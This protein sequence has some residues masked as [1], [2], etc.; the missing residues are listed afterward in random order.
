LPPPPPTTYSEAELASLREENLLLIQQLSALEQ[1]QREEQAARR[2]FEEEE[3]DARSV[4][5][6]QSE[7]RKARKAFFRLALRLTHAAGGSQGGD[8]QHTMALLANDL[9]ALAFDLGLLL[10]NQEAARI[11]T[12]LGTFLP[13]CTERLILWPQFLRWWAAVQAKAPHSSPSA[14]VWW[15][16]WWWWWWWMLMFTTTGPQKVAKPEQKMGTS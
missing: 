5:I 1:R 16:W 12:A 7:R 10:S 4:P 9:Q 11:A 13:D 3:A 14:V 15:W 8:Q 6:D 2:E